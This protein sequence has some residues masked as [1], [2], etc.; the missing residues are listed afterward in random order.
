M[1]NLALVKSE[2]FGNVQCDFWK[3]ENDKVFMTSEQLG[4]AL[5]YAEGR[6]S[7]NTIVSRNPYLKQKEFSSGI[8]LMSEAGLRQTTVFTEDGIYEV[9]FLAGTDKAQEFRAWVR[10]ILKGLRS[11]ELKLQPEIKRQEIEARLRN[12]KARQGRVL[13][14]VAEKFKDILSKPSIELLIGEVA[15]V[16]TG[17]PLL[18][19]PKV[20]KTYSAEEI[21]VECGISANMVGRIANTNGLKTEQYGIEVLDKSRYSSKQVPAWRYNEAGRAKI[22]EL[23]RG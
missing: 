18:A 8:N 12:S 6:K 20:E 15:E 16:T 9:T 3:G 1:S 19:K 13:L 4:Q 23:V 17:R 2:S 21:G 5:G 10:K 7:I 11:G 22:I 14:Q